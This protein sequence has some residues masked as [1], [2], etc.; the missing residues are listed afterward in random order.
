VRSEAATTF[1]NGK[2]YVI[3]GL[4][5]G[6]E[7]STLNQQ[8]DPVTDTWRE[9]AP[10]PFPLSH[11]NAAA[12]NN[13]IY[14]IGGFLSQVHVGAQEKALEYDPAA[15]RWRVLAPL[16]VP[17][18]SIGVAA[19]NGR[20]HAIGGRTWDRVTSAAHEVYDPATNSWTDAAALPR[21]RDHFG[22]A[23][24]DGRIH[25]FGGRINLPTDN[26][27]QHDI[28]DPATNAWTSG[29]PLPTARSGGASALYRGLIVFAG[30]ECNIDRPFS[31]NEGFNVKTGQWETLAPMPIGKHGITGT[32]DGQ[33]MYVAGGNPECGL[34]M[35]SRMV[36][37][38]LP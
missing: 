33:L 22:I 16:K 29:P 34:S 28:Y 27:N 30:G 26:T 15:D 38:S 2:I 21:A 4:A 5:R 31:T 9:M 1:A 23:V 10:M 3:G 36:T 18:G 12:L 20:I 6:L 37:F 17:R 32:T 25:V 13:R 7:A 8:Y 11:P 35:S 19:V 14:V 24:A